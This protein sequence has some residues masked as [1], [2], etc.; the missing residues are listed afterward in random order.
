MNGKKRARVIAFYLP[1]FHPI[2]ENDSWWGKGFTE[3]TNVGRAKPLFPGHY[4]PKVPADLG[5][6]DLRVPETR[7]EQAKL[8]R[9]AGI[10]GFCYWHYWFGNGRRILE[11][12]FDEVLRSKK[13][14]FPFCLCWA[15]HSWERNSWAPQNDDST[16]IEQRYLG[17]E[18][19]RRHFETVVAAFKDDRYM[20]IGNKPIFMVFDPCGMPDG[21]EMIE[22]WNDL[23][24]CNGFDGVYFIAYLFSP[25]EVQAMSELGYDAV[26]IDL[27]F[28]AACRRSIVRR[29]YRRLWR[30]P[31]PLPKA[32]RYED[33]VDSFRRNL[34]LFDRA[35]PCVLPNFD[36]TPR[37]GRLGLLLK[38]S[39]PEKFSRLLDMVLTHV[40]PKPPEENLVFIKAWNEWGEGNYLE[41][42][43]VYGKKYLYAIRNLVR[44]V[45]ETRA[46]DQEPS[47][48][49]GAD[50]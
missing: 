41:P 8:A 21:K 37:K 48:P 14:D 39:S 2:P 40:Q 45:D 23:A 43:L 38:G 28:A 30:R 4:Q 32:I 16:L 7:E 44:D 50:Q 49:A 9:E 6:Y 10:D 11:R 24:T 31:L 20:K 33:Y 27:I 1:Q 12:P 17:S 34:S 35:L 26:A 15:N 13:P 36:S 46:R 47:P 19:R 25:S 29:A 22:Q 18:D 3:W 5:Y 42:D